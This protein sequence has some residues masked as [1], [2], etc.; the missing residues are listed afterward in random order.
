MHAIAQMFALALTLIHPGSEASTELQIKPGES[1]T[2][3]GGYLRLTDMI[4]EVRYHDLKIP[5]II[6]AGISGQKADNWLTVDG[7]HMKPL[8]D[9]IMAVGILRAFGV[10]DT[11]IAADMN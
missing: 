4:L 10:P 7:V 9:T 6:K 8:G 5:P 11:T 1:I 3:H 2:A